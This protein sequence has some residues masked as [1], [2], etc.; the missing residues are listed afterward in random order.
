[1]ITN[2]TLLMEFNPDR[3]GRESTGTAEE[4]KDNK[5]MLYSG[6]QMSFQQSNMEPLHWN[7]TH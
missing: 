1:M 5:I 2:E 7:V 3:P 4:F 6:G